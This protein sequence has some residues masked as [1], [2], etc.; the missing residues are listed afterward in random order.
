MFELSSLVRRHFLLYITLEDKRCADALTVK[1]QTTVS[2]LPSVCHVKLTVP[3]GLAGFEVRATASPTGYTGSSPSR[4]RTSRQSRC[5]C[6]VAL[7]SAP[8]DRP[9]AGR[10]PSAGQPAR[11]EPAGTAHT[12]RRGWRGLKGRS[13]G[14]RKRLQT[15]PYGC[16]QAVGGAPLP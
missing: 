6:P 12:W 7:G 16:A 5:V 14:P 1:T 4:T 3:A 2:P 11:G 8:P 13:S 10:G 9:T 15:C